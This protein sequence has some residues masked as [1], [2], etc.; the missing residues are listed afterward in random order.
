MHICEKCGLTVQRD[1][2]SAYLARFVE[3]NKLKV[4]QARQAWEGANSLLQTAFIQSKVASVGR[5]RNHSG[6][7]SQSH[8]YANPAR[9]VT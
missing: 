7:P 4:S 8:S 5:S 6:G 9:N 3:G 2:F 1:L